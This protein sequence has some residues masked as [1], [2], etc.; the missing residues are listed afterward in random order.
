MRA[1]GHIFDDQQEQKIL[2]TA[3]GPKTAMKFLSKLISQ[4]VI[5]TTQKLEWARPHAQCL[6]EAR[7]GD[8]VSGDDSRLSGSV[9]GELIQAQALPCPALPG[10]PSLI[11]SVDPG[12]R[13]HGAR[14]GAI[15]SLLQL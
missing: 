7:G 2:M 12:K 10:G 3:P 9:D 11:R 13:E 15:R 6:T 4:R 8:C 14:E 5:V 1:S